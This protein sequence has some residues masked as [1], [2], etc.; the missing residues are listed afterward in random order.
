MRGYKGDVCALNTLK[1]EGNLLKLS[2]MEHVAL[3]CVFQKSGYRMLYT[4]FGG[5]F[6]RFFSLFRIK[7][8]IH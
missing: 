7:K 3:N 6:F 8:F 5:L 4:C 2:L 1:V